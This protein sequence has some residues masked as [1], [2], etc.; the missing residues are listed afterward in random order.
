MLSN[1]LDPDHTQLNV[2][3]IWIQT[4]C[5]ESNSLDQDQVQHIARPHI[6]PNYLTLVPNCLQWLSAGGTNR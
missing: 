2:G 3:L 1:S 6:D 4:V 5:K